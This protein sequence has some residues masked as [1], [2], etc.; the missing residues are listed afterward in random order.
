MKTITHPVYEKARRGEFITRTDVAK[1]IRSVLAAK[2]PGCRF[3]VRSDSGSIR[4]GWTDG[5]TR[6]QVEVVADEFETKGFDGM[7]DLAYS[8]SFWLLPDGTAHHAHTDGTSGSMGSV[9][10]TISSAPGPDAVLVERVQESFVFANRTLSAASLQRGIE[11]YRA[12]NWG[13][14]ERLGAA[15]QFS[16]NQVSVKP[17]TEYTSASISCPV[18]QEPV[19]CRWLSDLIYHKAA[20]LEG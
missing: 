19:S 15:G 16:W 10:E 5:P 3:S 13:Y 12:E 9:P 2:F 1:L 4:I 18:V 20:E 7:I 6:K 14:L 17:A 11:A 8:R